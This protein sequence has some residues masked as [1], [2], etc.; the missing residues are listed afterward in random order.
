MNDLASRFLAPACPAQRQY[1]AL[2]A[3][4]VDGLPTAEAAARLDYSRGTFRNLLSVDEIVARLRAR[5]LPGNA[6]AVNRAL[7]AAGFGRL[8]R[9]SPPAAPAAPCRPSSCG[10]SAAPGTSWPRPSTGGWPCS[11]R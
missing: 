1:E 9:A 6:K 10:A 7:R 5:G 8:P 11:P 4:C 3:H 2:R